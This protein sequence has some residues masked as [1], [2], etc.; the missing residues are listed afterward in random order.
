MDI[1]GEPILSLGA[2]AITVAGSVAESFAVS[3][4]GKTLI[5]GG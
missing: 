4:A 2:T 5:P 1:V 3:V